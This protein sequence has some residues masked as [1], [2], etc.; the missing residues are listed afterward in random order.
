MEAMF[1]NGLAFKAMKTVDPAEID[2]QDFGKI[3]D[4]YIR[5]VL[6][7]NPEERLNIT[8]DLLVFLEEYS[9]IALD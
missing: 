4:N 8:K 6:A 9:Q 7:E 5:K 3:I 2:M 1:N